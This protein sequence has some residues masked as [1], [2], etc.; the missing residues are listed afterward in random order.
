MH[1][2]NDFEKLLSR[3]RKQLP[4]KEFITSHTLKTPEKR[5][6]LVKYVLGK[7][8]RRKVLISA[9]IHGDEP[10]GVETILAF[11]EKNKYEKFLDKWEL[12][13]LPC[14]NPYGYEF[15]T[16]EN[17][18][19][20]DLNRL[21]K[22]TDPPI[23]VAFVKN[24]FEKPYDLTIELHE[25]YISHGYYLYQ[26]GTHP[27]DDQLG[28]KILEKIKHIMP[29]NLNKEIDDQTASNG[30]M[31]QGK[32][33]RS[34]DWWPMALYAH[35]KGTRR[36]LTLETAT[37]FEMEIRVKAHL[38]AIDTALNYFSEEK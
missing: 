6:P 2:V 21:F 7:G 28:H 34:M 35:S 18:D 9:G 25:D 27:E 3:L 10:C 38:H 14:I 31:I 30:I 5:Y 19:G 11:L 32:D 17:H 37:N 23:E 8:N 16:R 20:K 13:F 4:E 15:G 22:H 1:P 29:L 24:F 26:S 12:T 33:F 36:C